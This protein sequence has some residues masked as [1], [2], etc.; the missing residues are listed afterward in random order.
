MQAVYKNHIDI[1]H[2]HRDEASALFSV[3]T[4]RG[5]GAQGAAQPASQPGSAD[6]QD[7]AGLRARAF[8]VHTLPHAALTAHTPPS[9]TSAIH[10]SCMQRP[11]AA[12]W[13]W[14]SVAQ[15]VVAALP[16]PVVLI[17]RMKAVMRPR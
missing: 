16:I 4:D 9:S 12:L 13:A 6:A 15:A 14:C 10:Q 11:V 17:K 5:V 1:V 2:V 7:D 3:S 8:P